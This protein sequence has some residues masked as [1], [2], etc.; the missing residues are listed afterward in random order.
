[1]NSENCEGDTPLLV[2][3]ESAYLESAE[4]LIEYGAKVNHKNHLGETPLF[5]ASKNSCNEFTKLLLENGATVNHST[6]GGHTPLTAATMHCRLEIVKQLVVK[7]ANVNHIT[8]CGKTALIIAVVH[9]CRETVK[10]LVE[11]GANVNQE[12]FLDSNRLF[13][14]LLIAMVNN[15]LE[16]AQ[17]LLDHGADANHTTSTGETPLGFASGLK[18]LEAVMLL[19]EYGLNAEVQTSRGTEALSEQRRNAILCGQASFIIRQ[20]APSSEK[21]ETEPVLEEPQ[22]SLE[23]AETTKPPVQV[24]EEDA[25]LH[26]QEQPSKLSVLAQKE[27]IYSPSREELQATSPQA[28][29]TEQ[30]PKSVVGFFGDSCDKIEVEGS[31]SPRRLEEVASCQ[32]LQQQVPEDEEE[33]A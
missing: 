11:N 14:P 19:I 5:F 9:N 3:S 2:A 6:V 18:S 10:V 15:S 17:L 24:H 30:K 33:L 16:I 25:P 8:D 21:P 20:V 26:K 13:T 28:I 22:V 23:S 4:T 27:V 31:R 1:V 12:F 29:S 32:V 7:G